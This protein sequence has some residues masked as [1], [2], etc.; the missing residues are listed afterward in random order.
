MVRSTVIL[1]MFLFLVIT[2]SL[3][4]AQ[5]CSITSNFNGTP[6]AAGD[7]VWFTSVFSVQGLGSQPVT[8][9]FSDSSITFTLNGV[10]QTIPVPDGQIT[11][12]P[13]TT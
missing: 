12:S 10:L 13:A 9:S 7:T 4:N 11:F 8:V 1:S 6:I 5:T 2:T 3:V